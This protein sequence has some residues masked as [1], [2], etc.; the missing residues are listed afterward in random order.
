VYAFAKVKLPSGKLTWQWKMDLEDAFP[1]E[2]GIFHCQVGLSQC[3]CR[4]KGGN[5]FSTLHAATSPPRFFD[6]DDDD[7]E[8]KN[9]A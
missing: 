3:K 4:F 6:D 1:I 2:Q 8:D 5:S 9:E 7:D